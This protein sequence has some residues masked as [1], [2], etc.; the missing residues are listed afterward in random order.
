MT[1]KVSSLTFTGDLPAAALMRDDLAVAPRRH[2]RFDAFDLLDARRR[3]RR[4]SSSRRLVGV[5]YA[6][7]AMCVPHRGV[8]WP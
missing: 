7:N 6:A 8:P 1:S 3:T 2:Q 4:A 5:V